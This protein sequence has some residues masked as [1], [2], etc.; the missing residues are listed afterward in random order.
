MSTAEWVSYKHFMILKWLSKGKGE[1]V[2]SVAANFSHLDIMQCH[3]VLILLII[4]SMYQWK[5]PTSNNLF[6]IKEI[7]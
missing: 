4:F 7:I 6:E 2:I 5:S 1:K 3:M